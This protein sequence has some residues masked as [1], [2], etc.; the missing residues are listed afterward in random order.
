MSYGVDFDEIVEQTILFA[1][2]ESTEDFF[3]TWI[4]DFENNPQSV[5]EEAK[6]LLHG[7]NLRIFEYKRLIGWS[8]TDL[9]RRYDCDSGW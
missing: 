9:R 6:T 7:V 2:G 8:L 5:P 1:S 4:R 3:F